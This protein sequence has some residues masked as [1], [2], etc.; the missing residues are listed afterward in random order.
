MR[1]TSREPTGVLRVAV[2]PVLG[3]EI[4]PSVLA[5]LLARHPRLSIDARLSADYVDLRRGSIDVALRAGT[6]DD[7]SDLFAVRLG[8]SVS[9]C[10]VSPSYAASRGAPQTLADLEKHECILVGGRARVTWTFRSGAREVDVPVAG[11]LRV[12]SFRVARDVAAQ[13]AGVLRVATVFAEPLVASGELVPVLERHWIQVPVHAVHAGPN[14]PVARVRAFIE[15]ARG[16][17]VRALP[18]E[19]GAH[20]R[21][22]K[23]WRSA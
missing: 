12:D 7:A 9:G 6:L 23:R 8:V 13:G 5:T 18:P 20:S 22:G 3:E 2:A 11:R 19:S 21:N 14:P 10:Y 16:A 15:A 4:L 1:S 17:V